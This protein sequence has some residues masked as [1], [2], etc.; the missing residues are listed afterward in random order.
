V[1]FPAA[2]S[3]HARV[4]RPRPSGVARI[5][6]GLLVAYVLL[7]VAILLK[8]PVLD[9]DSSIVKLN[10]KGTYPKLYHPIHTYVTLGQRRPLTQYVL[11][12]L[13]AISLWRRT[14][15]PMISMF[16]AIVV[17][18]VSVGVVKV[19]T[20]RLGPRLGDPVTAIFSGGDIYP[21]GHVSNAVVM[22]GLVAM[23]AA[24]RLRPFAAALAGLLCVTIGLGTLFINTHWFTDVVGGWLAGGLVLCSLTW[25]VP[26]AERIVLSSLSWVRMTLSVAGAVLGVYFN[27]GWL[28]D[29]LGSFVNRDFGGWLAVTLG[30][31]ALP[32]CTPPLERAVQRGVRAV[33][34]R[35]RPR[36]RPAVA[37]LQLT[38]AHEAVELPRV[39]TSVA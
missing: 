21:S 14:P 32:W 5:F 29:G 38:G 4:P 12:I 8:T 17:L 20:G 7:T 33:W 31:S 36:P 23:F 34:H 39:D 9:I 16:V 30:L 35:V 24:P 1:D 13:L 6:L 10:L 18:N 26:P 25:L 22:Y 19:A 28:T 2:G 27:T 3:L 37:P 11:P 15:R